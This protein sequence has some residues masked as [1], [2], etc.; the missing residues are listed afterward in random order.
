MPQKRNADIMEIARGQASV[1]QGLAAQIMATIT[2]LPSGYNADVSLTKRPFMQALDTTIA[3]L[4]IC[5][6]AVGSLTPNEAALRAALSPE[7]FATDAAY[8]LVE[9]GVPFRDAYRQ[10]AANLASLASVDPGPEL[11]A[12]THQ[13]AS[14]NLGLPVIVK[15]LESARADLAERIERFQAPLQALIDGDL[16]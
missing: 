15:H 11:T 2:G 10:V 6:L 4:G 3:T 1:V 8:D 14:G 12:R 9:R 7:V 13:G 16:G 5:A